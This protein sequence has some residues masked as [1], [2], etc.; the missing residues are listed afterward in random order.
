MIVKEMRVSRGWS[1]ELLAEMSGLSVRTI[2]RLEK[3]NTVDNESLKSLAAVFETDI[4]EL[5]LVESVSAEKVL[6]LSHEHVAGYVKSQRWLQTHFSAYLFVVLVLL[7]TAIIDPGS[8]SF[9]EVIEVGVGWGV[10][11]L[12]HFF[13]VLRLR[14]KVF[15]AEWEAENIFKKISNDRK[16]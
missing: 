12:I 14:Q 10:A 2:Q 1:Q 3:G 4:S 11:V 9:S 8:N 13:V 5:K 7:A 6:T 16:E 15:N